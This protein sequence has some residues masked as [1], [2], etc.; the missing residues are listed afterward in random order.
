VIHIAIHKSMVH[1]VLPE[2]GIADRAFVSARKFSCPANGHTGSRS[3]ESP[4][5]CYSFKNN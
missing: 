5:P 3:F 1:H 2:I 4:H